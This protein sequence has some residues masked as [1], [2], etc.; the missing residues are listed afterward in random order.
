M[1]Y[2]YVII[3]R[4]KLTCLCFVVRYEGGKIIPD[5]KCHQLMYLHYVRSILRLFCFFKWGQAS[6]RSVAEVD[7]RRENEHA[8]PPVFLPARL[9]LVLQL[10]FES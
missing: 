5:I 2:N 4:I 3:I 10:A 7:L 9:G 6:R 8:S 1:I